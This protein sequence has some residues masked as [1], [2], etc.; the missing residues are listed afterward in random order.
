MVKV[1]KVVKVVKFG[2]WSFSLEK[3]VRMPSDL[4]HPLLTRIMIASDSSLGSLHK[5]KKLVG[6]ESS[7][8]KWEK[9]CIKKRKNQGDKKR[10][11]QGDKKTKRQKDKKTKRKKDERQNKRE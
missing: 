5:R 3:I 9:K 7:T 2:V 6:R 11:N 1:V 4:M 10:K 8:L